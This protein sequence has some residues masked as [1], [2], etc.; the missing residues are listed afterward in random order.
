MRNAPGE[1]LK[2]VLAESGRSVGGTERVVWELA[3][4]LSPQRFDVH[5]WL[6]PVK[7]LDEFAAALE[8]RGI[9][10]ERLAEVDSRWDWRGML[11]TWMRLRKAR[12]AVLHVHHVWPAADRYLCM[13]ARAAGVRHVVVTEHIVGESHSDTQRA[14]KRDELLRAD[15]VTAVCGAVADTLVRD[16]GIGRDRVRVVPNGAEVPDEDSEAIPAKA[17]RERFHASLIRPLWVVAGRLEDQKGHAVLLDALAELWKRGLDYSLV[18][19][20]DGTLRGPLEERARTLGIERKIHFVGALD[21]VGPLLAASDA[22]LLP[23]LWEGLPLI[24]LEAMARSRP[25]IATAVG[26]VPEL[27]EHGVNGHL[28]P[29]SDVP[30]LAD[31]LELFHRKTDRAA[32]MGRAGGELVRRD[33]TWAA[34]ADGFEAVYDDVLGLATFSPAE[35]ARPRRGR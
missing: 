25:V 10:V 16:Y 31:A 6:S 2:V 27:I 22:V 35:S 17:W 4:R 14:L 34:V 3:T 8:A 18:V 1:R 11:D 13:L 5:V 19:A 28:V 30:A 15:A 33:Y 29:P 12:P 24:L 23:S 20:G 32:R 7:E 26:G 21:D 9:G